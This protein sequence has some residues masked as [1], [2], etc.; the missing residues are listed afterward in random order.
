[1]SIENLDAERPVAA[2]GN[3][4]AAPL[5]LAD[6]IVLDTTTVIGGP[7]MSA[8]LADLGARVI[9]IEQTGKGDDGRKLGK[10]GKSMYWRFMAR[11]KECITCN[12]RSEEGRRLFRDLTCKA[13]VV[14]SSFRPGVM[15]EWGLGYDTLSSIN[16]R[17]IMLQLSGYGQTGPYSQRP[18][19]G[20]L[21]EAMSGL[22][23]MTGDPSGPPALPGAPIADPLASAMGALAV[24][25]ALRQ[26]DRQAGQGRG[27]HIDLSLYG[28]MLYI[29]GS[30]LTEYSA[31]GQFP[32][33]GEQLGKRILRD[34][35]L[36]R[37]EKWLVFSVISGTLIARVDKMLRE[38]GF[39]LP[40]DGT[41]DTTTPTNNFL[42]LGERLK[43][44]IAT[45]SRED[46]L[47]ELDSAGI[48]SAPIYSVADVFTNPHFQ[49]RGDFVEVE[50]P[51]IGTI[52]MPRAPFRMSGAD[53]KVRHPGRS[54]GEDNERVYLEMLGLPAEE[55]ARLK[56][57]GVI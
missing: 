40:G 35:A 26:R 51:E 48:P 12:L 31:T 3:A 17:L 13:D 29:L 27:Q 30:Y 7:I 23:Y 18:G 22:V 21:A 1:M 16:P 24:V 9:K 42:L 4:V 19:Y 53:L 25:S 28:P 45:L 5:P 56:A 10:S 2:S 52:R 20:A 57:D 14:L 33:R 36:A 11:N 50:D 38:R 6:T 43:Q 49:E 34:V 15:E 32:I 37:D 8:L 55:L 54:L 41:Y 39:E 44:W 46:A 47:A